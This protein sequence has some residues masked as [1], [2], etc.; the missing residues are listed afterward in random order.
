MST[1]RNKRQSS[2]RIPCAVSGTEP[3]GVFCLAPQGDERFVSQQSQRDVPVPTVSPAHLI[4]I[5]T[6]STFGRLKSHPN[7]PAPASYVD[8]HLP[9]GR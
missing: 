9:Y 1:R 7:F 8:Q 6:A 5:E 2:R 3:S 4:L